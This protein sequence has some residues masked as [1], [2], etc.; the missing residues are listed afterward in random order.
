[1]A[2]PPQQVHESKTHRA[3]G[4]VVRVT[5]V[6]IDWRLRYGRRSWPLEVAEL[7]SRSRR[8]LLCCELVRFHARHERAFLERM[9]RR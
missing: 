6:R 3:E 9:Q 7:A 1:V 4:F 5:H 8:V 2:E